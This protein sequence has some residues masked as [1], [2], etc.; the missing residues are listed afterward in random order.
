MDTLSGEITLSQLFCLP[1]DRIYSKRKEFAPRVRKFFPF[2]VDPFL[3]GARN[4]GKITGSHESCF[5]LKKGQEIY[6]VYPFTFMAKSV[7]V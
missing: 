4:A 3:E 7:K 2:K 6:Q 5:P 1:S